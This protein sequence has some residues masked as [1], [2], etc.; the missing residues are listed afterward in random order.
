M[1]RKGG[2]RQ[3][4]RY[5]MPRVIKVPKKLHTWVIRAAAGPHPAEASVPLGVILRDYLHLARNSREIRSIL[6][7]GMVQVDGKVR[8]DAKFPVGFMD[9]LSIPLLKKSFR[10]S[11]NERGQLVLNEIKE[12]EGVKLCRVKKKSVVRGKKI[13]LTFH[14]GRNLVGDYKDVKPGDTLKIY[15]SDGRVLEHLRM[16]AGATAFVTGGKNIGKVG[17]I[18]EIKVIK[19][20]Q[21]NT[22]VLEAGGE[23]FEAPVDYVFVIGEEKPATEMGEVAT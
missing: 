7:R 4:K 8:R 6:S 21:Y 14:D 3:L 15:L 12:E 17:R 2:E 18:K 13:Q 9:V 11:L 16:R 19:G 1:A 5:A 23:R 10:C 20:S 22:A